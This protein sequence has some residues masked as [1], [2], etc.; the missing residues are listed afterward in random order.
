[1]NDIH[2]VIPADNVKLAEMELNIE[3]L[4]HKAATPG[5][6]S[7]LEDVQSLIER[8]KGDDKKIRQLEDMKGITWNTDHP[9]TNKSAGR[10]ILSVEEGICLVT[11]CGR[12]AFWESPPRRPVRGPLGKKGKRGKRGKGG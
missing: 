3:R 11:G 9:S 4:W 10:P 12:K 8:I 6:K 7:M 1:M 2:K 5:G